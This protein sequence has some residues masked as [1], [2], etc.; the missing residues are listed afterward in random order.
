MNLALHSLEEA[1]VRFSLT[2]YNSKQSEKIQVEIL[3]TS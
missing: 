1:D 3:D 2:Y